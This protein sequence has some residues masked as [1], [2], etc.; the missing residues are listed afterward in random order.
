M[1]AQPSSS[2]L[3]FNSQSSS[4]PT[5]EH[6]SMNGS[7]PALNG[8]ANDLTQ[9]KLQR[10]KSLETCRVC[11][12][13]PAR[14]HYGVPTCFG[15][16]GFFRRTLKRTKEYTCRYN[17]NCVVDRYERNSCRYCRFKRCLEVGMDPKAV[18]P[19]RDAAG[20]TH[21]IR[22]RRSKMSM[23]QDEEEE[24]ET[25]AEWVRK[26][27][28]DMRTLL[29][30]IMNIDLMVQSGD[31]HAEPLSVYPLQIGSLRH[32]L[33]E[34]SLLDGKRIEMR[35]EPYRRVLP[36]EMVAVAHRRLIEV[37]DTVDHLSQ[38][39]DLHNINDKLALVKSAYAPLALFSTVSMTARTTKDRDVFCLCCCGYIARGMS[40]KQYDAPYHFTNRIVD[41]ALDELVE[42]FRAFNFKEQEVALMKAIVTLNPHLRT[43][44]T[45][46]SEQVADLRDRIQETLYNVVRESHP[47]EVASSRFGN[48]LLFLPTIMLLGNTMYENLQF[49]QS[50]S[51]RNV[52][53]LLAE[54]LDNLDPMQDPG[55]NPD[56]FLNISS[57][58]YGSRM[59]H[60]QSNSSISSMGSHEEY[61]NVMLTEQYYSRRQSADPCIPVASGSEQQTTSSNSNSAPSLEQQP[62]DSDPDY[63]VTLTAETFSGMRQ[64]IAQSM[65]V[66][67]DQPDQ[68]N[69]PKPHF[70][71]EP[72]S[73]QNFVQPQQQFQVGQKHIFTVE[74]AKQLSNYNSQTTTV[75]SNTEPLQPQISKS[76]S[77]PY[78]YQFPNNMNF[79]NYNGQ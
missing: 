13:G 33:E 39:M 48:L 38:L 44:S 60:S 42:P 69:R 67:Q 74:T 21:P 43:L 61:N 50:F 54:L 26:L 63:N 62:Q 47:K 64:A 35:Y 19:D 17:G 3:Q 23:D 6:L 18:R 51:N 46:G 37:I 30:Q 73:Q 68:S 10:V 70:Y 77:Y 29:M 56:D 27:P 20:R 49:L 76:Q 8:T 59:S 34:P 25:T 41:R 79:Q 57:S 15:C 14:M 36:D 24:E 7:Q 78:F 55:V 11:G 65:E 66:D 9:Q 58:E 72:F 75:F 1:E 28:V 31:T 4:P 2:S 12:D 16:K 53:P 22:H 52:D 32:I 71:I 40:A 45:E 5:P